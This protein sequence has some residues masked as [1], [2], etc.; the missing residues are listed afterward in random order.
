MRP[1]TI[2]DRA[3]RDRPCRSF[4]SNVSGVQICA[5]VLVGNSNPAGM[6]PTTVYGSASSSMVL[7]TIA[8]IRS[9]HT[10]PER[11]AEHDDSWRSEDGFI[12]L[13]SSAETRIGLEHREQLGGCADARHALRLARSCVGEIDTAVGRQRRNRAGFRLPV[14]IGRNRD[15]IEPAVGIDLPE[16]R[17]LLRILIGERI[18]DDRPDDAEE[19]GVRADA[20]RERQQGNQDE[21]RLPA[22]RTKGVAERGEPVGHPVLLTAQ[23]RT[24]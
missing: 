2:N 19:G 12:G 24:P 14:L 8:W 22:Q 4:G 23:K 7:P 3:R 18:E 20:Q 11:V 6:T 10:P 13:E 15:A 5:S 17:D 16:H 21:R 1:T 9:E